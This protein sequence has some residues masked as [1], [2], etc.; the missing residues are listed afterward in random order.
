MTIKLKTLSLLCVLVLSSCSTEMVKQSDD[1]ETVKASDT[2]LK[3]GN[4]AHK[5]GDYGM[6][7]E[8]YRKAAGQAEAQFKLGLMYNKGRG[9][10]QNRQ[11]AVKWFRKAAEQGF[12]MAQY[13][14]GVMYH[15]GLGVTQNHQEALKWFRKGAEQGF[16]LAQYNLGV[17]YHNGQGV[18]QNHEE[19]VK[20]YRKA[21]EQ[22]YADA[23]KALKELGA[24]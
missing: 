24:E 2:T 8:M 11:E 22:G 12:I 6:A 5:K 13:N 23:Q 18:A 9:V 21:A 7:V 3:M 17:M 10:A 1:R 16:A 20:W 19:A 15:Q 4:D 14:L